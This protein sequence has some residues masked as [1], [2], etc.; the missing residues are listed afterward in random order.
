MSQA[1]YQDKI[2]SLRLGGKSKALNG[3]L[4]EQGSLSAKP[5]YVFSDFQKNAFDGQAL[6]Q[7]SPGREVVLIPQAKKPL[8]N[9]YVD[10][11]WVEDAFVRVRTNIGLNIRLRNGGYLQLFHVL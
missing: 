3:V 1:I 6:V 2:N 7:A 9:M 8:S 10:S 11:L 4:G 5:L